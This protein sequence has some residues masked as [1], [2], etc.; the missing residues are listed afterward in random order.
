MQNNKLPLIEF[1]NSF[2]KDLL[3]IPTEI[4]IAIRHTLKIFKENPS[5][6]SLRNHSLEILGKRCHGLFSIDV[7]SDYRAVYRHEKDK[8]IFIILDTHVRLYGKDK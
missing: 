3:A 4:K 6:K 1:A 7:T 5:N 8:I 2:N